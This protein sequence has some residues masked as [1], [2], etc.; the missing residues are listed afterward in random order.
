MTAL[1]SELTEALVALRRSAAHLAELDQFNERQAQALAAYQ[2]GAVAVA[3]GGADGTSRAEAGA[4]AVAVSEA[5]AAQ[6]RRHDTLDAAALERQTVLHEE[7]MRAVRAAAADPRDPD[8]ADALRLRTLTAKLDAL[9]A[10]QARL[11]GLAS[12]LVRRGASLQGRR[13][14]AEARTQTLREET[15]AA[16]KLNLTTIREQMLPAR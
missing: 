15:S 10:E 14:T 8:A 1:E 6:Q 9:M 4:A 2:A 11:E 16:T 7:R 5:F 13:A 12:G 3:R